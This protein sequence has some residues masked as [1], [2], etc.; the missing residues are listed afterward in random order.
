[1]SFSNDG[2]VTGHHGTTSRSDFWVVKLDSLRNIQWER[3]LGGTNEDQANKII[4]TSDSGFILIGFSDSFD[5]DITS[6]HGSRDIW[7]VKLDF[8]ETFS[9][10]K[11]TAE[12]IAKLV[13]IL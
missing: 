7:V 1:M 6:F 11:I 10:K 13:Q 12:L 2:N 8:S 4:Q 3:S 5:G 9:G